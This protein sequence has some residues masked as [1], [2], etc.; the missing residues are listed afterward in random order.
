MHC[1][2]VPIVGCDFTLRDGR[3]VNDDVAL[4]TAECYLAIGLRPSLG[5]ATENYSRLARAALRD[6]SSMQHNLGCSS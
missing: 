3:C 6:P 2:T 4:L 1:C 5:D